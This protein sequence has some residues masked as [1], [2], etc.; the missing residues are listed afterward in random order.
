ME[1]YRNKGRDITQMLRSKEYRK[2][3]NEIDNVSDFLSRVGI[4]GSEEDEIAF[5]R[6]VDRLGCPAYTRTELIRRFKSRMGAH[7]RHESREDA[8][9]VAR[10]R[11]DNIAIAGFILL[12]ITFIILKI[13]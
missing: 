7:Q 13:T 3:M 12:I 6:F 9:R 5:I 1:T 10:R 11:E 8:R 4:C 2:G